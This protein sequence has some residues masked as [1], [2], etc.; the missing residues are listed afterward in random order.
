MPNDNIRDVILGN[1]TKYAGYCASRADDVV[2]F[3]MFGNAPL[4]AS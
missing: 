2:M 3:S 4:E 1:D